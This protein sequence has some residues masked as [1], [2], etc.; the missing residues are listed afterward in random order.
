MKGGNFTEHVF[1]KCPTNDGQNDIRRVLKTSILN[2]GSMVYRLSNVMSKAKL[3]IHHYNARASKIT[4]SQ[5][6][7]SSFESIFRFV[8][9]DS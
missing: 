4:H 6:P 9:S 5:A 3:Q 1:V 8:F 7:P 2:T